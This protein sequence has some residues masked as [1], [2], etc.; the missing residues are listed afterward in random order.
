MSNG[1]THGQR[2]NKVPKQTDITNATKKEGVGRPSAQME[3]GGRQNKEPSHVLNDIDTKRGT[4][5]VMDSVVVVVG[6]LL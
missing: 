2:N 6:P 3:L 4:Y 5:V 1:L